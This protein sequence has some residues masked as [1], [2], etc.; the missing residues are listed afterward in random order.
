MLEGIQSYQWHHLSLLYIPNMNCKRSNFKISIQANSGQPRRLS[1]LNHFNK[2]IVAMFALWPFEPKI[3]LITNI[4]FWDEE[5][6]GSTEVP[7]QWPGG[8][9]SDHR[10]HGPHPHLLPPPRQVW[11]VPRSL[12]KQH[13]E[14][15]VLWFETCFILMCMYFYITLHYIILCSVP[16]LSTLPC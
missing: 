14:W 8:C 3:I 6:S 13:R 5:L 16:L 2:I 9:A 10:H 1:Y 15:T 4:F 12:F 7:G 11:V